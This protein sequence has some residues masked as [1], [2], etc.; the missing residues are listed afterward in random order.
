MMDLFNSRYHNVEPKNKL[1][2]K[3][4]EKTSNFFLPSSFCF[5]HSLARLRHEYYV[6][7]IAAHYLNVS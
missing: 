5:F 1:E 7:G 4:E 6:T 2:K 3:E